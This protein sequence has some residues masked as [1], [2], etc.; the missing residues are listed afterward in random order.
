[1]KNKERRR[2][3]ES[4]GIA[5]ACNIEL[6]HSRRVAAPLRV[7]INEWRIRRARILAAKRHKLQ[8]GIFIPVSL[9][10]PPPGRFMALQR[11]G[12]SSTIL[13][14]LKAGLSN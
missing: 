2:S 1:M 9:F 5:S 13:T 8:E 7:G 11:T 12:L 3:D 4:D 14:G 6:R 10:A